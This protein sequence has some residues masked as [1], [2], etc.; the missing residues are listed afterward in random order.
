MVGE[1]PDVSQARGHRNGKK[2]NAVASK[3][4]TPSESVSLSGPAN[5]KP[6]ATSER[7]QKRIA[8][9]VHEEDGQDE[10]RSSKRLDYT[11]DD[12][13]ESATVQGDE[14]Q[15]EVLRANNQSATIELLRSTL[16]E[17]K[18]DIKAKDKCIDE[19]QKDRARKATD[20]ETYKDMGWQAIYEKKQLQTRIEHLQ[21]RQSAQQESVKHLVDAWIS[22]LPEMSQL[23]SETSAKFGQFNT[24][25]HAVEA[26]EPEQRIEQGLI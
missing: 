11:E 24:P 23:V 15:I 14:D 5:K 10:N 9:R 3:S 17:L 7:P 25:S 2:L 8:K 19:L 12:Q 1:T 18:L 13:S 26:E 6:K 21:T 4:P 22:K 20:L 16:E